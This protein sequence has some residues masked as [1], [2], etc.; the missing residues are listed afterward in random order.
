MP[1]TKLVLAMAAAGFAAPARRAVRRTGAV[2]RRVDDIL[3]VL[4]LF[5]CQ[6][7]FLTILQFEMGGLGA[8]IEGD[9]VP[10]NVQLVIDK[11]SRIAMTASG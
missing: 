4:C 8:E 10:L 11:C 5:W 2:R 1:R 7:V 9:A 6:L 3:R